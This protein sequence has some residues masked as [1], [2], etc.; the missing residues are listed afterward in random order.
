MTFG[1]VNEDADPEGRGRVF[2]CTVS[3]GEE[4]GYREGGSVLFLLF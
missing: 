1:E 3:R 2:V 4:E